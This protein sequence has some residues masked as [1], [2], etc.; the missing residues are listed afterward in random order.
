MLRHTRRCRHSEPHDAFGGSGCSALECR[1]SASCSCC[2]AMCTRASPRSSLSVEAVTSIELRSVPGGGRASCRELARRSSAASAQRLCVFAWWIE[3]IDVETAIVAASS[4]FCAARAM[5]SRVEPSAMTALF[6]TAATAASTCSGLALPPV[7]TMVRARL[8]PLPFPLRDCDRERERGREGGWLPSRRRCD[9]RR[10]VAALSLGFGARLEASSAKLTWE[11]AA[12]RLL[13]CVWSSRSRLENDSSS[14]ASLAARSSA[15]ASCR[16]RPR[17]SAASSPAS[18]F[19][20]I[21]PAV[22]WRTVSSTS[23]VRS[24]VSAPYSSSARSTADM[25]RRLSHSVS[26]TRAPVPALA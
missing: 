19:R 10:T 6:L 9:F 5:R 20:D 22:M 26:A 7:S 1:S 14:V 2:V 15:F 16:L 4:A 13:F 24:S 18:A 25:R 23:R 3:A 11:R 12:S 8:A 17:F 21:G